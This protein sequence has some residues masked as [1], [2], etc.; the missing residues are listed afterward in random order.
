MSPVQSGEPVGPFPEAMTDDEKVAYDRLRRRVLWTL[1][2]GLYLIGSAGRHDGAERLNLMAANFVTQVATDPKLVG[3]SVEKHAITHELLESGGVFSLC[4][5]ARD[6]RAI[7]R[8][9]T[10]PVDVDEA[11]KT[12]ND[13]PFHRGLTGA[14]ILESAPAFVECRVQQTVEAGSHSFF[15]GEVVNAAFQADEETPVLRMED[16]RMNYGG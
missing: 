3:V 16:T 4:T 15:I 1:P 7:I 9:F 8:K 14:P 11:A 10:K 2:Y 5:V 13:Y 6:D 12:M